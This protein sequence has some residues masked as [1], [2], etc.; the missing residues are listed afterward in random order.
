MPF[1]LPE[2]EVYSTVGD[3]F[4]ALV[5]RFAAVPIASGAVSPPP[6]ILDISVPMEAPAE[7]IPEYIRL[8][9]SELVGT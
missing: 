2:P 4:I 3:E 5:S 9:S 8:K 6:A 7:I 1:V